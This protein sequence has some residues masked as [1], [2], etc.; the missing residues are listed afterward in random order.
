MTQSTQILFN[1]G[2]IVNQRRGMRPL[3]KLNRG[4]GG[5]SKFAL[6]RSKWTK[7]LADNSP[8]YFDVVA[9]KS[10]SKLVKSEEP[11][12]RHKKSFAN[13]SHSKISFFKTSQETFL[14]S[15]R[16]FPSAK[17][18]SKQLFD[19]LLGFLN[20]LVYLDEMA[21]KLEKLDTAIKTGNVSKINS[22]AYD[23]AGI[24]AKCGMLSAIEP[25]LELERVE[26]T[27]Q[28]TRAAALRTQIKR[29]FERFRLALERSLERIAATN[30][31][32]GNVSV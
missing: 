30:K 9:D 2:N 16:Q 28:M 24:S 31:F 3:K 21:E 13:E 22:I 18:E 10:T 19:I 1:E 23:C 32:G 17:I 12:K 26:Q 25:L 8:I 20:R 6:I 5:K 29:E 15:A 11:K 7:D 4:A 14:Q 27:N